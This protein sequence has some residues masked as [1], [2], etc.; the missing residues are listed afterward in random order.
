MKII[1]TIT[2]IFQIV[3]LISGDRK[4]F[5]FLFPIVLFDN[6]GSK[7]VNVRGASLYQ[8]HYIRLFEDY[9]HTSMKSNAKKLKSRLASA[10]NMKHYL[11]QF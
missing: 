8:Q 1:V 10:I 6:N 11:Q 2:F 4:V 3:D 5:L 7:D 9:L